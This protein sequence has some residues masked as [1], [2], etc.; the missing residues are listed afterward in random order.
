[1]Q[2]FWGLQSEESICGNPL[3]KFGKNISTHPYINVYVFLY[4]YI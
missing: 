4:M 2:P 1:M 3:E